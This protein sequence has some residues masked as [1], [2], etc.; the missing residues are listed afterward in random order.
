MKKKTKKKMVQKFV[1]Q[2]PTVLQYSGELYCDTSVRDVQRVHCIA[3]WVK[4]IVT[5]RKGEAAGQLY[6]NTPKCIAGDLAGVGSQ[7]T[8]CIETEAAGG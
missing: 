3:T 7:Y 8:E 5:E 4:C 6:C 1:G 2:C